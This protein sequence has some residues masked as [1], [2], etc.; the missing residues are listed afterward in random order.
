MVVLTA[1]YVV[2]ASGSVVMGLPSR[3]KALLLSFAAAVAGNTEFTAG[4]FAAIDFE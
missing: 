3:Y 2:T 1:T 4:S